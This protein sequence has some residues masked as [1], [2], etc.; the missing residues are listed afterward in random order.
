MIREIEGAPID[1]PKLEKP[2]DMTFDTGEDFTLP[3]KEGS[4][5]VDE[6]EMIRDELKSGAQK[7][8]AEEL[9]GEVSVQSEAMSAPID[10]HRPGIGE[11][12]KRRFKKAAMLLGVFGVTAGVFGDK[13]N[14]EDVET[15]KGKAPDMNQV[16]SDGQKNW[17]P[18][19]NKVDWANVPGAK[20]GRVEIP[21]QKVSSPSKN[22]GGIGMQNQQVKP[23]AK[24]FGGT[25]YSGGNVIY[26]NGGPGGIGGGYNQPYGAIRN[27]GNG[28]VHVEGGVLVRSD[29]NI[30]PQNYNPNRKD[31][32]IAKK[33]GYMWSTSDHTFIKN[34]F[35]GGQ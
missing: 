21:K 25:T 17:G 6:I 4:V 12:I 32:E 15:V 18:G 11:R 16:V 3:I 2:L 1:E 28:W 22:L 20:A 29:R 24:T 9:G 7:E 8:T 33:Q 23:G 31:I 26:E 34:P 30:Y 35:K 5:P 10:Y 13:A 14:A 19:T 27:A